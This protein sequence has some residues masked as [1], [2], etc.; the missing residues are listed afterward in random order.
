[1]RVLICGGG[2]IGAALAYF[3]ALRGLEPLVIERSGVANAASGKSGGFLALDWCDGT[4][5][6]ALARRSFALHE[7]LAESLG[8][9]WGYRRLET[10]QVLASAR[11]SFGN[12]AEPEDSAWLSRE[13]T[14]YGRLGTSGTTAQVE[15]AAFTQ[16]LMTAAVARG[17]LLREGEVEEILLSDDGSRVRGVAVGGEALEGDSVVVAMGPWS[18]LACQWLPLPPVFGLK[19]HSLVFDYRP[20]GPAQA[21]FV[22]HEAADGTRDSPEVFPRAD[23]TTYVCGLS[24]EMPLPLDPADVGADP[25]AQERLRLSIADVSPDL[26]QAAV[27]AS[28]ACYRPVTA[29]SLPLL[30]P[31]TGVE[32]AYVAT[33]HNVWGILNAPASGEA[34]AALIAGDPTGSLDLAAFDPARLPALDVSSG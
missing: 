31:V 21:L 18:V 28:G 11:G 3:L 23:G 22:E 8:N 1:M 4:A 19:G 7:E 15:P 16:G 12:P 30:G 14:V 32:G 27:L 2:A 34:M 13:A 9:P 5:L 20:P 10:L 25:G 6:E 24:S 29:D 26:A 17:G 33:G